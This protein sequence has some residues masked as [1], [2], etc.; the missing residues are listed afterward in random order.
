MAVRA[1]VSVGACT[2]PVC[3]HAHAHQL[4]T[5]V[6]LC[7]SFRD[8]IWDLLGANICLCGLLLCLPI[9]CINMHMHAKQLLLWSTHAPTQVLLVLHTFLKFGV[10]G[11][12]CGGRQMLLPSSML[13]RCPTA[14]C[15]ISGA[16]VTL[17]LMLTSADKAELWQSC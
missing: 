6:T 8:A 3:M 17:V 5:V 15:C 14:L 1:C 10:S 7:Q 4:Y 12:P 13:Y 16:L 11:R 9:Y 2:H